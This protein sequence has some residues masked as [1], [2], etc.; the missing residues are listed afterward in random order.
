RHCCVVVLVRDEKCLVVTLVSE[1]ICLRDYST[2][3]LQP[4]WR[5]SHL[6][7]AQVVC[8]ELSRISQIYRL[9]TNRRGRASTTMRTVGT[10]SELSEPVKRIAIRPQLLPR[11][12]TIKQLNQ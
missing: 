1:G 9:G 3:L 5:I 10:L 7:S 4:L 11:S 2:E 6:Y 8:Y 12:R